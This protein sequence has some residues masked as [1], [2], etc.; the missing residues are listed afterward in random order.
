LDVIGDSNLV[1]SQAKGD[2]KVKEEKMRIYHQTS[3][4][5]IP[6]FKKLNF[7]HLLREN[8]RFADSLATLSSM[9]DISFG[10]RMRPIIIDPKFAPAYESIVTIEEVQDENPWYYDVWN[11]LEKEVYPPGANAKDKRAI[12][13]MAA[14]FIICWGK[15]YKRGHLGMHKLCV[16]VEESKCL[17]EAIHGRECGAHMNGIML[18]RKILRQGYYWST[19]EED[20]IG[21][22]RRCY[23]C[24]IH[25]NRMNIPPSKLYNMTSPWPFLV[26][27]IDVIGAVTS[28]GSN[29]H[30]FILVAIEYFTKWVEA[31][32]YTV[33]KASHV[34]SLSGTVSSV[35][36]GS[37]TRLSQIMVPTSRRK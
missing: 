13:R 23:K 28:K 24:Q 32:S 34:A 4:L 33:L 1:V 17:M 37:R 31:Q 10:V 36:M 14:Q 25:A 9:I 7:A 18:A 27:G 8:N 5:L 12:R 19:R 6:R 20:C 2:W 35:A 26:W 15:L 11:F 29:G 22:V 21:F 30:E 3:D 16:E